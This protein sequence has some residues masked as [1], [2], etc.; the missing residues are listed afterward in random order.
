MFSLVRVSRFVFCG[1][2]FVRRAAHSK[3]SKTKK[4]HPLTP[5]RSIRPAIVSRSAP[6]PTLYT[7]TGLKVA[8]VGR[9][10]VG[11]STLFN[12]LASAVRGRGSEGVSNPT[13]LVFVRSVVDSVP[14]VTRDPR[15]A[16]AALSDLLLTVVDTPGLENAIGEAS[17]FLQTERIQ[18]K[19]GLAAATALN[20]D[21]VYRDLYGK[22][23]NATVEAIANANVVFFIVDVADGVTPVDRALAQ[24]LRT[25][26]VDAP[27]K[28]LLIAN[29]CDVAD[30]D[31]RIIDAFELGFGDPLPLSAEQGLGFADLYAEVE[32]LYEDRRRGKEPVKGYDNSWKREDDA[33]ELYDPKEEELR[34]SFDDEL[35]VG[36]SERANE[37]PLR[38]LIVSIIGRPN[39]GKSTLMNRLAGE[40]RSLVGPDAG[41]TRDAVLCEWKLPGYLQKRAKVPV[42]LVDTAGVRGQTKILE[43][44]LELL[45]VRTS[46]RALR[47]SHVVVLVLDSRELLVQQDTKLLDLVVTEGRAAV[48]VV[49]K[50]DL[51]DLNDRDEWRMQLRFRVDK[52]LEDLRGIEVVEMSAK[53]WEEDSEQMSRLFEAVH[54]AWQRW[55]KRIPTAQLNR[56]VTK[57]NERMYV[58]GGTR[59]KRNR[60]GVTKFISQRK[61]RP[62][63]FRL[64]GSSAVS[65]NY[66][67]SLTN[68]LRL[69]FGFEGVPVRVKR[70]SRSGQ[71]RK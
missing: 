66:V 58:G 70:P 54:R 7:H 1:S 57:F 15:E 53:K 27:K 48:L 8:I 67:R 6:A 63:M 49:N 33:V 42:W 24:W 5:P 3:S 34:G 22:M 25:A 68:A 13:P 69:E 26:L 12:R 65:R 10:N 64:D 61:I 29:K 28:V 56:F 50:M 41:V 36:I 43:E 4:K 14:G 35:V 52:K 46:F 9:P 44:H 11:K 21:P 30:A 2:Q 38:Q 55:E 16:S 51:V 39:V 47:H 32:R 59:A 17:P 62:P 40:E 18:N 60:I 37:A 71:K 23:E 31:K 19:T 20:D 45:S